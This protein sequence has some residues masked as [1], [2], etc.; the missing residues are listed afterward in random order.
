[1]NLDN[2]SFLVRIMRRFGR[3]GIAMLSMA[4]L[5]AVGGTV[6]YFTASG[7]LTMY[8]ALGAGMGVYKIFDAFNLIPE[9]PDK[10]ITLSLTERE[11]EKKA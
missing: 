2:A 1:V 9:D 11:L 3:F 6:Y 5:I 8:A 10:L 7:K 4:A